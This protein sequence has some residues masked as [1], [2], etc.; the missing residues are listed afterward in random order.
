MISPSSQLNEGKTWKRTIMKE[1]FGTDGYLSGHLEGYE[2][3]PEQLAMA[4]FISE[5]LYGGENSIV[6]AGTGIGKTLAYLIPALIFA[7]ENEKKI[8]LTTETKTLQKQLIDKDIPLVKKIMNERLGMDFSYS[9]CL[10]SANYPCR[11]RFETAVSTGKF[12]K[13]NFGIIKNIQDL[14]VTEK[15]FTRFDVSCPN[16]LWN[17]ICREPDGCG[18]HDCSY[19]KKCH[20]LY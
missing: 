15:P 16:Y 20:Q 17:E 19:A 4:E 11:R 7:K 10:G 2:F 18:F 8:S 1:I 14:F 3:R 13:K 12:L 6:E 9:L 5:R